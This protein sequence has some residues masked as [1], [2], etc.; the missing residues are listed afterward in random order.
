MPRS[1]LLGALLT[2]FR[3]LFTS[4][5]WE[6]MLVLCRGTLLAHGRRTVTA[7]LWQTGQEQDPHFSA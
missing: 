7:A 6:N 3:P 5:T 1:D 2:A 4:P